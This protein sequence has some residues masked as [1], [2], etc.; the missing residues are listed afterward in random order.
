MTY[1]SCFGTYNI[2]YIYKPYIYINHIYIYI[3]IYHEWLISHEERGKIFM[4][5]TAPKAQSVYTLPRWQNGV[6]HRDLK[7]EN[8]LLMKK[9]PIRG[10]DVDG[11]GEIFCG[12]WM[13][14]G[15]TCTAISW[16]I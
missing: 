4:A 1:T 14:A 12:S 10:V 6:C 2:I 16:C 13:V 5:S 15:Y 11:D 9:A 7:P 3:N 8:F